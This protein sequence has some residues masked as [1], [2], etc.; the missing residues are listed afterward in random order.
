MKNMNILLPEA[1][2][3]LQ[4]FFPQGEVSLSAGETFFYPGEDTAP[5]R[6]LPAQANKSAVQAILARDSVDKSLATSK[7]D[8]SKKLLFL[9]H[10]T[11]NFQTW[12]RAGGHEFLDANGNA[13]LEGPN[14]RF[15]IEGR[16]NRKTVGL[17]SASQPSR[18][19]TATGL[20]VIFVLLVDENLLAQPIRT[21]A[22][23]AGV[24]IGAVSQALA[25][26][27][28]EGYLLIRGR[29]RFWVQKGRLARRWLELYAAVLKPK[30]RSR[31]F[32]GPAPARMLEAKESWGKYAWLGGE[33]AMLAK[34]YGIRPVETRLYSDY[35][36]AGLVRDFRLRPSEVG[37]VVLTEPFWN[38]EHFEDPFYVP[39]L[40]ILAD[41]LAEGDERQVLVA[42]EMWR[43]DEDLQK[44]R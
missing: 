24:S 1:Q 2:A 41:E 7:A 18:A 4:E 14:Y 23:A 43:Q 29:K 33:A 40:L 34:G 17:G 27:E 15:W 9:P 22:A 36:W 37:N 6:I 12:L 30:L 42:Q 21:I 19:F 32:D 26:L 8:A 35:P 25:D 28:K 13:W 10:V 44:L 39:P 20:R 38:P 11:P 16:K 31:R 5:Y 3:R